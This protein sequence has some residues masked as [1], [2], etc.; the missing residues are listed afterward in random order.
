MDYHQNARLTAYSREQL[1]KRVLEQGLTPNGS[2][3]IASTEQ[4]VS[5]IEAHARCVPHGL[6]LRPCPSRFLPFA[7]CATTVF[8]S[9]WPSG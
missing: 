8:G 9:P 7:G 6:P 4:P 2:A 5:G 3:A 1:A